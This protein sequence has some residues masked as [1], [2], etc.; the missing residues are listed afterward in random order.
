M[1]QE[2]AG[3]ELI[4]TFI[5]VGVMVDGVSVDDEF[6]VHRELASGDDAR[7]MRLAA[8]A[9]RERRVHPVRLLHDGL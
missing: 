4:W 7:L 1:I 8:E 9:E 2:A 5:S 3:S 6:G